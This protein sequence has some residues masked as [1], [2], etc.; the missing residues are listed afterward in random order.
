V[1]EATEVI[2][3]ATGLVDGSA[4]QLRDF[5]LRARGVGGEECELALL[6]HAN[7]METYMYEFLIHKSDDLRSVNGHDAVRFRRGPY[8]DLLKRHERDVERHWQSGIHGIKDLAPQLFDR[9]AD[10]RTLR[11]A[12]DFL[13]RNGGRSPGPNQ[14]RYNDYT[15]AEVWG[16]CRCLRDILR[17]GTYQPGPE[18]LVWIDKD[19]GNGRRPIA[20]M[21]IEDRVV[22]RAIVQI[23]QPVLD[24]L[25]DDRSNGYRPGRGPL[26]A[27]A[28]AESL[29]TSAR[30]WVWVA[31]DIRDAFCH[32]PTA[33]LLQIMRQLLPAD[34]L[35]ALLE[36]VL[37]GNSSRGLRQGGSV[38]PLMLNVYLNK[39]LDRPWRRIQPRLPLIRVADDLLVLC[40]DKTEAERAHAEL[41]RLLLPAGLPLKGTPATT[42]NDLESHATVEW[43]GLRANKGKA[44]LEFDIA[45]R[46]WNRLKGHF[47]L[48]HTL[49]DSPLRARNLVRQWL[50]QLGPCFL[51]S[52]RGA[53]CKRIRRL[54]AK[55]AF[56]EIVGDAR[57]IE[58]W[59][60]AYARW[61]K[62]RKSEFFA[63]QG[64]V[65]LTAGSGQALL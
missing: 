56:E 1:I 21:N 53:V 3:P 16:L 24:R 14:H 22:Q 57:L 46:A 49:S 40:R 33:R 35:M 64:S 4:Y 39:F 60:R 38:S 8:T 43:L 58:F 36:R 59:Q 55:Q 52:R 11:A 19:S 50:N 61:R 6:P 10:E 25:F 62:I 9:I 17:N 5:W 47:A 34:N 32:V 41:G 2:P 51:S 26:N 37:N 29:A 23:L 28:Q 20:L 7:S 48:V 45:E 54:A 65:N 27:L 42:I 13:A 18:R 12:W 30:R 44:G 15:S 63:Q 31:E